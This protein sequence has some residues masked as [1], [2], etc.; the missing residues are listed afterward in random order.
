MNSS[1]FLTENSKRI[2]LLVILGGEKLENIKR[3]RDYKGRI[4][5]IFIRQERKLL[6]EG[7]KMSYFSLGCHF[8]LNDTFHL[9]EISVALNLL[10]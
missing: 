8:V 3:L 9:T 1:F 2:A 10:D 7:K 5:G 4:T 6:G